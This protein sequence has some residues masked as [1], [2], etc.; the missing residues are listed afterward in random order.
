MKARVL[1]VGIDPTLLDPAILPPGATHATLMDGIRE[2]VAH[3]QANDYDA[4]WCPVDL[5][6]TAEAQVKGALE[7]ARFQ[8]VVIGAGIRTGAPYF[9]LFERLLNVVH[10][11]APA[12]KI[13]FNTKPGDTLEAVQRWV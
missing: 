13:C 5:G 9:L 1:Y 11:H 3:L 4:V 2:V 8:C 10:A 12:A 6:E 7:G